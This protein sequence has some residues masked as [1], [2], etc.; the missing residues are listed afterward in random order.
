[1]WEVRDGRMN[2]LANAGFRHQE[3]QQEGQQPRDIF[4]EGRIT[5][6]CLSQLIEKCYRRNLGKKPM[7]LEFVISFD[8]CSPDEIQP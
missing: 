3:S 7:E 4:Q 2:Y 8:A 5:G 1:M 6:K